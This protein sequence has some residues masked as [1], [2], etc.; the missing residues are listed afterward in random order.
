MSK[1]V[2]K[3]LV[4]D[5][6]KLHELALRRGKSESAVVRELIDQAL[7]WEEMADRMMAAAERLA[8]RG[9]IDDVFG[10]LNIDAEYEAEEERAAGTGS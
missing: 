2:R 10:K 7:G 1:L 4:L 6:E 8:A 9:G 5:A 3:N